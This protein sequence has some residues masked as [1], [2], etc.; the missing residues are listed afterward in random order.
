VI[1][2]G[3]STQCWD[4][5]LGFADF[6]ARLPK[7]GEIEDL[8][9]ISVCARVRMYFPTTQIHRTANN[10]SYK[11][12]AGDSGLNQIGDIAGKDTQ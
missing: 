9:C 5:K 8:V 12:L 6:K 10:F 1:D 2:R 3:H 11:K 4:N 7:A